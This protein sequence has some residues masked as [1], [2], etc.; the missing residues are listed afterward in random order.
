MCSGRFFEGSRVDEG[1]GL[2]SAGESILV[3]GEIQI[4]PGRVAR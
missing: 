3:S 1:D 4:A 2:I